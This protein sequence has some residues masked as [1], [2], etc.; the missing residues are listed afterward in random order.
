VIDAGGII[1]HRDVSPELPHIP[2]IYELL[3]K[4]EQL[5]EQRARSRVG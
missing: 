5:N 4:L 3:G 1:R 2:D